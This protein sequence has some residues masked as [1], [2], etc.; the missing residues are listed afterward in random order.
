MTDTESDK[1]DNRGDNQE[2]EAEEPNRTKNDIFD[3]GRDF[4]V[5]VDGLFYLDDAKHWEVINITINVAGGFRHDD[6]GK[7][8]VLVFVGGEDFFSGDGIGY[9]KRDNGS[10][11][12]VAVVVEQGADGDRCSGREFGN[13]V[14]KDGAFVGNFAGDISINNAGKSKDVVDRNA[15]GFL[16]G[17]VRRNHNGRVL[18]SSWRIFWNSDG[19]FYLA[20]FVGGDGAGGFGNSNPFGDFGI[21][22]DGRNIGLIIFT[23][24]IVRRN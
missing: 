8:V 10:F 20:S 2:Y 4:I 7:A 3:N 9:I 1:A 22:R 13:V 23:D 6:F 15:F 5:V 16:F 24:D 14:F 11:V 21:S 18:T 19:E 17:R 12:N